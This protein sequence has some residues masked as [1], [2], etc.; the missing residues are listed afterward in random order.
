MKSKLTRKAL[1]LVLTICL[2]ATSLGALSIP[3]AA[4]SEDLT[5]I[6]LAEFGLKAY[7]EGW[8][9]EYGGY[10]QL[11][12]H[13]VRESDCSGLIFAY[14]CW[15]GDDSDPLPDYNM[16]RTVTAQVDAAIESGST[17]DLPRTHGL[18]LTI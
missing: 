12:G 6:G 10:G 4:A 11:N 13:G 9:Y 1:S 7:R 2:V 14:L 18:L 17:A 3:A 16:P 8:E 5:G 15:D